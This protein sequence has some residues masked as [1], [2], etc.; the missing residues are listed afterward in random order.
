MI[1]LARI[2][3]FE[4]NSVGNGENRFFN[5]RFSVSNP[6]VILILQPIL[7]LFYTEKVG[8]PNYRID[9]IFRGG[10]GGW[11]N[12]RLHDQQEAKLKIASST[13]SVVT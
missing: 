6:F 13:I 11:T 12:R 4:I 2:S 10:G 9:D 7:V 5:G 8:N 1:Y 3:I